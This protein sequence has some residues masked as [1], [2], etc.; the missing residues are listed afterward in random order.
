[1]SSTPGDPKWNNSALLKGDV[2]NQVSKLK[3]DLNG[4][5]PPAVN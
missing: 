3:Q 2:M 4:A 1:V 5:S